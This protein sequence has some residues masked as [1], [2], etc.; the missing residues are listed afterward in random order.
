M[1]SDL[2]L[3]FRLL[4]RNLAFTIAAAVS[5][6]LAIGGNTAVFS[7]VNRVLLEPLPFAEA[8]RL[9]LVHEA[10]QKTRDLGGVSYPNFL[11]W[12]KQAQSFEQ[13]AAFASSPYSLSAGERSDRLNGELV[14][15]NY[16]ELLGVKPQMGRGFLPEEDAV[17]AAPRSVVISHRLW[18]EWF[19]GA[20]DVVGRKLRVN[21]ATFDVVGV[22]PK[23][24]RGYTLEADFWVPITAHPAL[25]PFREIKFLEMRDIHWHM[26]LGRLKPGVTAAQA[27]EEMRAIGDRLAQLEPKANFERTAGVMAAKER[28]VARSRPALLI[29]LGA[30]GLVLLVA[31]ANVAGLLLVRAAERGREFAIRTSLG[32]TRWRLFRQSLS[33][34]LAL[35]IVA[36]GLGLLLAFWGTGAMAKLLPAEVPA[37]GEFA[38]NRTVL[39]FSIGLS[40]VTALLM[41][42]AP[43]LHSRAGDLAGALRG[44]RGSAGAGAQ[45][46]RKMLV[47]TEVA[48]ALVL[49]VASGVLM[50]S[51]YNL[52]RADVGFD[53]RSVVAA[54]LFVPAGK[55]QGD[56]ANQLAAR[57]AAETRALPG[58]E[59]AAVSAADPFIYGGLQRF[60]TV[61]GRQAVTAP[62]IDKVYFQDVTPEYFRTMRLP[63]KAGRDFDARETRE[64]APVA[65]VSEGF[66]KHFF[67]GRDPIGQ[68]LHY[69]PADAKFPWMTVVGVVADSKFRRVQQPLASNYAVYVPFAQDQVVIE[70]SVLARATGDPQMALATIVKLLRQIEPEAPIYNVGSIEQRLVQQGA[71]TRAYLFLIAAFAVIAVALAAIGI[72]GVMAYWVA[73]RRREIG[74]RIAIGAQPGALAMGVLKQGLGLAVAGTLAG[75]GAAFVLSRFL[76]SMVF[77]VSPRDVVSFAVA[78]TVVPVIAAFACAVPAWRA[79]RVDPAVALRDE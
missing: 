71:S 52:Y 8:D 62:E 32:A 54:R 16:L 51:L 57:V 73:L 36:A 2:S 20:A 41:A 37:I 70:F 24:F 22:M 11:D 33:D 45:R 43:A 35:T 27:S 26:A 13:L 40:L 1:L 79:S 38:V 76:Q 7:V 9:V 10:L 47:A 15:S 30:V 44:S 42:I 46:M 6:A 56:R 72:Y 3:S 4:R 50:R 28:L 77:E 59:A 23:G 53:P 65:I 55:Y 66:A 61:E 49:L 14:S 74:I 34:S 39:A 31:C 64:S 63:L 25:F 5:L 78:A 69:G 19:G 21:D 60:F 29:L 17:G 58:I 67:A 18:Q 12:R 48:I 68:R 75:V